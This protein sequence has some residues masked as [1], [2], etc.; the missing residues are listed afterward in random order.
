MT[1]TIQETIATLHDTLQG[2][3]EATY[4]IADPGVV[5]QRRRLLRS[6]GGIFQTPFLESTPRY[7]TGDSYTAMSDIPS[8]ARDAYT[9]LASSQHGKPLLFDPP[10]RHQAE[11]IQAILRDQRNV[12]IMTGTG[13]GKT[14]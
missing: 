14:E 13:S 1:P 3:I 5:E 12:M 9:Q 2:Y 6:A 11:S 10:Y 4:H 7:V 8:A